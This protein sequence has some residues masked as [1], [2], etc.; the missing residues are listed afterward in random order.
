MGSWP[1]CRIIP[2][3]LSLEDVW[4]D[5]EKNG[6]LHI[7]GTFMEQLSTGDSVGIVQLGRKGFAYSGD[8]GSALT[9]KG[10]LIAVSGFDN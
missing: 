2:N 10:E 5:N 8:G 6:T 4:P 1:V 3:L 9:F 7:G